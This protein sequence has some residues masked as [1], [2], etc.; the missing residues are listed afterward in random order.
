M[1]TEQAAE[2]IK[3]LKSINVTG[4]FVMFLLTAILGS[5]IGSILFLCLK[6]H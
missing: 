6:T 3:L 4:W 2:I 1:T 5:I